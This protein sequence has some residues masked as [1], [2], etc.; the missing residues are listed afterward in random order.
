MTGRGVVL[1]GLVVALMVQGAGGAD[2]GG[3]PVVRLPG[4][5]S[6]GAPPGDP[7]ELPETALEDIGECMGRAMRL[8]SAAA[9]L[10][11]V[12]GPTAAAGRQVDADMAL[13]AAE[14]TAIDVEK[15]AIADRAAALKAAAAALDAQAAQL[16][17]L[18]AVPGPSAD[19][20]ATTRRG[21]DA[22]NEAVD[23]YNA[24]GAAYGEARNALAM[25]IEAYNTRARILSERVDAYNAGVDAYRGR[26]DGV[27]EMV[28]TQDEHCAGRRLLNE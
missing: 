1:A 2:G 17:E 11:A 26:V 19:D 3:A 28:A 12:H 20:I 10:D 18:R 13:L 27:N 22:Y 9:D 24:R 4:I 25:R 16:D 6:H 14:S 15:A 21:V 5:S 8:D 23:A 7:A